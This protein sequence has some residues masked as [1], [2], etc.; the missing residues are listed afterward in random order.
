MR[1]VAGALAVILLAPSV[2]AEEPSPPAPPPP[3]RVATPPAAHNKLML[4]V[5]R[6][7]P[8]SHQALL[9]D[10]GRST[11]L[12]AEV[13]GKVNGYEVEDIDD[14]T[15]TLL[16]DG[17]EIVLTA[18]ARE[19]SAER[20][21]RV[22]PASAVPT[23]A[24]PADAQ[25]TA[26]LD[27]YGEPALRAADAADAAPST[28][29]PAALAGA[30]E[31]RVAMAPGSTP[32]PPL[33]AAAAADGSDPRAMVPQ[34]AAAPEP[35]GAASGSR[36]VGAAAVPAVP[37]PYVAAGAPRIVGAAASAPRVVGAA[38]AP[39]APEPYGAAPAPRAL[40]A[41]GP[42]APPVALDAAGAASAP[43]A[44]DAVPVAGPIAPPILAADRTAVAGARAAAAT[45]A[46]LPPGPARPGGKAA[47]RA[48]AATPRVA[49]AAVPAPGTGDPA[50]VDAMALANVMTGDR[51]TGPRD[52]ADVPSAPTRAAE[53]RPAAT[54]PA[55]AD[56][57][58]GE[59]V[60]ISRGDLDRAL[61]DFTALSAG[62]HG[63]FSTTGFR[64]DR[65]VDGTIFE[66][67]GLRAGDVIT[68]VDGIRPRSIDDAA[69]L[70]ARASSARA[71][72]AQILRNARPA[73][74]HVVIQ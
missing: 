17:Q 47:R 15:V 28:P 25:D 30:G 40:S 66:R 8:E 16:R 69:N 2:R 60:L 57:R 12:L 35:Y 33:H 65:V 63:S 64:I 36:V 54:K 9:Y 46:A 62:L 14:D 67:A 44:A 23:A 61:A 22:R 21:P 24:H 58:P 70:Y 51:A 34:G 71:M 43:R 7:M 10:R 42:A 31:V 49:P 52:P 3:P 38:A 19:A 59:V 5:V 26:P 53:V 27:P 50:A 11:H 74:L 1:I 13:G 41:A 56:A 48:L 39:M 45:D 55:R 18:P 20:E 29:Q 32:N 37:A 4:R 68:A 72:S 73:T 6:V